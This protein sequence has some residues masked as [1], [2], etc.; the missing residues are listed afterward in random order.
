MKIKIRKML[1]SDIIEFPIEF[2]KQGWH[3]SV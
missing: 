3:K 1:E 2:E